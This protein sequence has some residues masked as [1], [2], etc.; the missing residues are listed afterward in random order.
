MRKDSVFGKKKREI[1]SLKAE[2][3]R[4]TEEIQRLRGASGQQSSDKEDKI[5]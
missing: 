5:E 3:A 1:E 4:L 2:N